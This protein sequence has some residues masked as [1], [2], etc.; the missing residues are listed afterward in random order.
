MGLA[1]GGFLAELGHGGR[2]LHLDQAIQV[3]RLRTSSLNLATLVRLVR[4]QLKNVE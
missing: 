2:V 3:D 1:G 4:W